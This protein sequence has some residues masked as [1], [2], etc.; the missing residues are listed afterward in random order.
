MLWHPE[1]SVASISECACKLS[2]CL[3][4]KGYADT[5]TS[6]GC[7]SN[8]PSLS[9]L[10]T[11]GSVSARKGKAFE[12]V[13]NCRCF[14]KHNYVNKVFL[15]RDFIWY[16]SSSFSEVKTIPLCTH[17]CREAIKSS[18]LTSTDTCYVFMRLFIIKYLTFCV[19]SQMISLP[20]FFLDNCCGERLPR[21]NCGVKHG[22]NFRIFTYRC[23]SDN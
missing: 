1:V 18:L 15:R 5:H 14:W 2:L 12:H 7:S 19:S 8:A 3:L 22:A 4:W 16:Y 13:L 23:L 9:W 20:L 17:F 11:Q 10:G 6:G 21:V